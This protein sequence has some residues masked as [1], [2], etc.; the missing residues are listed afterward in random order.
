M[1][2]TREISGVWVSRAP[3]CTIW[4]WGLFLRDDYGLWI[5]KFHNL[6]KYLYNLAE[7][8]IFCFGFS[9]MIALFTVKS[10]PILQV[11]NVANVHLTQYANR[12][13]LTFTISLG[14]FTFTDAH[15]VHHIW[16]RHYY[17][18]ELPFPGLHR[19][20]ASNPTKYMS[21][22]YSSKWENTHWYHNHFMRFIALNVGSPGDMHCLRSG[23]SWVSLAPWSVIPERVRSAK[24]RGSGWIGV[25]AS[26][27]R[28]KNECSGIQGR[29]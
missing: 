23:V 15:D 17:D 22:G 5:K 25:S 24:T 4:Y 8:H 18:H 26:I 3:I 1:Q 9:S 14:L 19:L 28:P 13:F 21:D 27:Y 20:P 2:E 16:L 7:F 29:N 12:L 11:S 6:Y 10:L